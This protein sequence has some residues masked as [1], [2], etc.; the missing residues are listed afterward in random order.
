MKI[1]KNPTI[2]HF[3]KSLKKALGRSFWIRPFCVLV[4]TGLAKPRW[5]KLPKIVKYRQEIF[6]ATLK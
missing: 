5:L 4:G 1:A 2:E 3:I 6:T